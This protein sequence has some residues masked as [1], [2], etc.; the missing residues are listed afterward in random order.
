MVNHSLEQ[1]MVAAPATRS[2][3]LMGSSSNKGLFA[4]MA[5]KEFSNPE[6]AQ[7]QAHRRGPDRRRAVQLH[8]R[9][10]GEVRP[11]RPRRAVDSGRHRRHRARRG[12]AD[13]PRR[14]HAAD[15]AELFPARRGRLQ[16]PGE[17]R[18]LP[19][20]LRGDDLYVQQERDCRQPEAGRADHQGARRSD[21]ALLRRQGV[22]GEDLHRLRQAAGS[23]R[24]AHLR[25]VR[26]GQHLRPR[27][28]RAAARRQGDRRA[29]G[30]SAAGQAISRPTT[31]TGDRQQHRRPAG[32][33]RL[34]SSSCSAPA[35]KAEEERAKLERTWK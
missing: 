18:R 32:E 27:S 16:E 34:S 29:A 35:I 11:R 9:A 14:R 19:R 33:G 26:Q 20:R 31:S 15:R 13:Q 4:L 22:R 25:P 7:G 2:F 28:L 23:R 12:A 10:A 1:G 24:R 30:R 5:Q 3:A 17:P 8:R 6:A 21:Q